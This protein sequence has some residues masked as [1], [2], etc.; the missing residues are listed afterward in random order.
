MTNV[1]VGVEP[2]GFGAGAGTMNFQPNPEAIPFGIAAAIAAGLAVFARRRRG[3]P[4]ARAFAVMMIGEAAWALF[5]AMEL[6]IGRLA[7]E[8]DGASR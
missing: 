8:A 5:E 7:L 1:A 3:R 2:I 4:L 6:V